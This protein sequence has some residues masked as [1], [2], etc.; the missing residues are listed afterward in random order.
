MLSSP[1]ECCV[2]F[3][4]VSL[5]QKRYTGTRKDLWEGRQSWS[6]FLYEARSRTKKT[7]HLALVWGLW[8]RFTLMNGITNVHRKWECFSQLKNYGLLPKS[9][10][11]TFKFNKRKYLQMQNIAVYV[12]N[13]TCFKE[14][15]C[16]FTEQKAH[17]QKGL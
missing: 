12:N 14:M 16:H 13:V 5:S 17:L 7:P 3:T 1:F 11:I 6:K 4:M 15:L 9:L 8:S 2:H 10:D